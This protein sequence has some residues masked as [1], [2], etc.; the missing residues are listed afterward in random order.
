VQLLKLVRGDPVVKDFARLTVRLVLHPFDCLVEVVGD[1]EA[2]PEV[3][4]GASVGQVDAV[5]ANRLRVPSR[6]PV[7]EVE[8]R[9][10]VWLVDKR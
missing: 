1:V 4:V 10:F 7:V 3:R 6:G 8:D 2:L 9:R 5:L